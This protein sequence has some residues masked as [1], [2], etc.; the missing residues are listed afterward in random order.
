MRA[1]ICDACG[2][3][4]RPY[5]KCSDGRFG[6]GNALTIVKIEKDGSMKRRLKMDLCPT[7]MADVFDYLDTNLITDEG[8]ATVKKFEVEEKEVYEGGNE[9][10]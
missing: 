1:N 8:M 10:G 4:Y 2:K 5:Y 7:C 3:T 9:N 6:E